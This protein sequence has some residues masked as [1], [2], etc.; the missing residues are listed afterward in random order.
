V[1][2]CVRERVCVCVCAWCGG[3][4]PRVGG[5]SVVFMPGCTPKVKLGHRVPRLAME[6]GG[7]GVHA[8]VN[9]HAQQQPCLQLAHLAA[10]G[11]GL[12]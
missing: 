5:W 12:L 4:A 3:A 11:G 9:P 1:C 6:M 10:E 7:M 8:W 2:V